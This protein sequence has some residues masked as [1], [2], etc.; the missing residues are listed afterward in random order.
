[1]IPN[2]LERRI[3]KKVESLRRKMGLACKTWENKG[4]Q[5]GQMGKATCCHVCQ[6]EFKPLTPYRGSNKPIPVNCPL[7]FWPP[8][9]CSG[10]LVPIHTYVHTINKCKRMLEGFR[11]QTT[12][13]SELGEYDNPSWGHRARHWVHK[14]R[15]AW[16]WWNLPAIDYI[17]QNG[18]VQGRRMVI[19]G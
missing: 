7:N 6:P 15:T 2:I 12:Y 4:N 18:R 3:K 13:Q 17:K 9:E 10:T 5:N 19:L 14:G 8:L 16:N 1:M 11:T